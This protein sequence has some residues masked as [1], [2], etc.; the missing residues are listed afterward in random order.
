[1]ETRTVSGQY[2]LDP[3]AGRFFG[4]RTLHFRQIESGVL[5]RFGRH[6]TLKG[7]MDAGVLRARW[8]NDARM[9]WVI[10]RFDERF[11]GFQGEYG[12][13]DVRA[14]TELAGT[15]SARRDVRKRPA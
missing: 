8:K 12:T 10:L 15:I 1:M 13:Y 4:A 6:G 7:A 2:R 3:N 11:S 5:G 9:G 14:E